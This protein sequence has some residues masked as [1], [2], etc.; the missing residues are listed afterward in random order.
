LIMKKRGRNWILKWIQQSRKNNRT[1]IFCFERHR[2]KGPVLHAF[3]SRFFLFGFK[4][5]DK[6]DWAVLVQNVWVFP[7]F[8]P[9]VH[10]MKGG[11][12]YSKNCL[13][14]VCFLSFIANHNPMCHGLEID[15]CFFFL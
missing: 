9:V 12:T 8:G 13:K 5:F 14:K 10:K 2:W 1:A 4:A 7:S 11:K 15:M 6:M 3:W